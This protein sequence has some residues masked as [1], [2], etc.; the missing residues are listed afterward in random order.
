VFVGS[1]WAAKLPPRSGEEAE[2][3]GDLSSFDAERS[4]LSCQL[5]MSDELDGLALTVASEE[6]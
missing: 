6:F 1:T 2:L 5:T 3:L 4:R